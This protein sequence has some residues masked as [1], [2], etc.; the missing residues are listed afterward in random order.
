MDHL[1]RDCGIILDSHQCSCLGN[2]VCFTQGLL[3]S[4]N[5]CSVFLGATMLPGPKQIK[6]SC[7]GVSHSLWGDVASLAAS[8]GQ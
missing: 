6:G 1:P 5:S 4:M 7:P 2:L 3:F 8:R